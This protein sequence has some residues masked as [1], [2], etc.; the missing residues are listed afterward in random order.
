MVYY[1][2]ICLNQ[3][4]PIMMFMLFWFTVTS[5]LDRGYAHGHNGVNLVS[6]IVIV[7]FPI[8]LMHR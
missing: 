1:T 8:S 2:Y 6:P 5:K 3:T 4:T 7:L